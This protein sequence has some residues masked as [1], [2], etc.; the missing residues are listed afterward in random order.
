MN[1]EIAAVIAS[2]THR[3]GASRRTSG[4][5]RQW[6]LAAA[7]WDDWSLRDDDP[8]H[9]DLDAARH[10][11]D[12]NVVPDIRL[13]RSPTA[14][15]VAIRVRHRAG[16]SPAEIAVALNLPESVVRAVLD[17]PLTRALTLLEEQ[18]G[19]DR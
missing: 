2:E 7:R 17:S 13:K 16:D 5:W 9:P 11:S 6:T 4:V 3:R 18:A 19:D 10:V 12:D 15:A 14:I 8:R 1:A